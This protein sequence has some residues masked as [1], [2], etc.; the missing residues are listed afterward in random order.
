[1]TAMTLVRVNVTG[2]PKILLEQFNGS[3]RILH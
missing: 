3:Q 1:M 2:L